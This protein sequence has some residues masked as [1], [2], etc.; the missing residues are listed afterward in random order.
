MA[1]PKTT[2]Q[3]KYSAV[4]LNPT[5]PK[6]KSFLYINRKKLF[7]LALILVVVLVLTGIIV[8]SVLGLAMSKK[9]DIFLS[10]NLSRIY[11]IFFQFY[12][13]LPRS[14]SPEAKFKI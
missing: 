7:V 10:H 5:H 6:A 2:Q 13:E 8:G 14:T 9:I 11:F 3:N 1:Y 12:L 4:N